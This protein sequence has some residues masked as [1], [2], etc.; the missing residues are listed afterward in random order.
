MGKNW[1][2]T[3]NQHGMNLRKQPVRNWEMDIRTLEELG[4]NQL[5]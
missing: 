2:I 4:V 1:E 3:E 5:Q